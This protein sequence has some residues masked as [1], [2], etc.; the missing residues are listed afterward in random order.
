VR[1]KEEL[2]QEKLD[3]MPSKME[4][5]HAFVERVQKCLKGENSSIQFQNEA[6]IFDIRTRNGE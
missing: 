1:E 5:K 3:G 6:E 2:L 4:G